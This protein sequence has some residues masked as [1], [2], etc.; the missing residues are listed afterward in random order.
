MPIS[1]KKINYKPKTP[2]G[3]V[4]IKQKQSVQ[5]KTTKKNSEVN[6]QKNNQK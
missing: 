5:N 6:S 4:L 2:K 3:T 1:S